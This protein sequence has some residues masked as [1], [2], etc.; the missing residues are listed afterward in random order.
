MQVLVVC[1]NDEEAALLAY[2]LERAGIGAATCSEL[3]AAMEHFVDTPADLILLALRS[4]DLVAPVRRVR[5]ESEA[6]LI[7]IGH[8]WDEEQICDALESGADTV[9]ARP[10]SMPALVAQTRALLRRARNTPLSIL[11]SF[12]L[13]ALTLDPSMRTVQVE[14]HASRRLTQLEFRL[15]YLLMLHRNQTVPTEVIVERVWG[16]DA[17]AGTEIV[18]GL[19]RRLRGKVEPDPRIPAYIITEPTVGYRLEAS[20]A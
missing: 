17:E 15:L 2:A 16:Y 10:Y 1:D 13:G 5:R 19:V 20:G 18:R 3:G 11:P 9:V 7:A 4:P 8:S 14:G 6:C 12:T